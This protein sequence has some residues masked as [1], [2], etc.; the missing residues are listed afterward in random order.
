MSSIAEARRE[1]QQLKSEMALVSTELNRTNRAFYLTL[2]LMDRSGIKGV[3]QARQL[4][5]LLAQLEAAYR[6]VQ[7][8][9]MAAGD[10]L[11]WISAG[12]EVA[13]VVMSL[14]NMAGSQG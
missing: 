2:N 6:A 7:L 8:A 3:A 11:A 4:I 1:I 14:E 9:R 12:L 5:T 10:P 13:N